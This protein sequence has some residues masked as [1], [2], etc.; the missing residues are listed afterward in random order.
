MRYIIVS[1]A[2]VLL[3]ISGCARMLVIQYPEVQTTNYVELELLNGEHV[4]G[5]VL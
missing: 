4:D 5:T 3:I 2:S 1:L